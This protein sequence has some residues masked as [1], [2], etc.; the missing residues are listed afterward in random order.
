[1]SK[2]IDRAKS[3]RGF[4]LIEL[5]I[6]IIVLGI[7]VAIA[8]PTYLNQQERARSA[9][10]KSDVRAAQVA[11]E[12][13]GADNDGSYTTVSD[14]TLRAIEPNLPTTNDGFVV[15]TPEAGGYKLAMTRDSNE[16]AINKAADGT[17]TRT[18]TGGAAGCPW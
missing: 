4:T 3:E 6:V 1:M 14:L 8:V 5:L 15:T 13:V 17:V 7:L 16:F 11:A 12:E 10:S 18:C 9:S 2:L